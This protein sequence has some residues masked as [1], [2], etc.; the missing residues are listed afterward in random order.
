MPVTV[1]HDDIGAFTE[2]FD[3][4]YDAYHCGRIPPR[5]PLPAIP[6]RVHIDETFVEVAILKPVGAFHNILP[7]RAL[8][9]H[10]SWYFDA[11]GG[12]Y[13]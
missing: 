7:N 8:M 11:D 10:A 6:M 13:A 3:P 9:W 5:F 12:D 2:S 4:H 1:F